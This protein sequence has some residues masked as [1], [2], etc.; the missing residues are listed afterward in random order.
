VQ[1]GDSIG[2]GSWS[3]GYAAIDH[4][5]LGAGVILHNVSVSGRTMLTGF[6]Q[7][8][9]ELFVFCATGITCVLLIEQGTND[10]SAGTTAAALYNER[11]APFVAAAKAAGFYVVLNSVL[12]RDDAGWSADKERE[13]QAYNA[14]VCANA[15]GADAV[16][17][18]ASDAQIGDTAIPGPLFYADRLHLNARGQQ[19]L[20]AITAAVIRDVVR[21]SPRPPA[22]QG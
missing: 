1:A 10:L 18:I 8:A 21:R 4:L 14:L 7:R 5:G 16:N 3:N 2:T 20:A 6:G 17:D 9:S 11:A 12:P 19:R 13:R 22:P 15:A